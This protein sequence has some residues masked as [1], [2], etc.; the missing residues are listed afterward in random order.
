[1]NENPS[2]RPDLRVSDAD[3]DAV[4]GELGEHYQAGR[5]DTDEFGER[6]DA[7]ASA[8]TRGEL[9]R[10]MADL[11]RSAAPAPQPEPQRGRQA[12]VVAAVLM[13]VAA[14]VL[15]VTLVGGALGGWHGGPHGNWHG[16]GP[17]W[18]LI[19][20]P[21]VLLLRLARGSR[22]PGRGPR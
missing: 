19:I 14:A 6:L 17:P 12:A 11:P 15:A 18:F 21:L 1:M 22:G 7:A 2:E 4:I 5:L 3:Q 8:R 16:G 20:I 13:S 10:L 9:N